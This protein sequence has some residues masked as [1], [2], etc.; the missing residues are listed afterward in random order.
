MASV[1][2]SSHIYIYRLALPALRFPISGICM[3]I[4]QL[5]Q[6][7]AI[8]KHGQ[9]LLATA[10]NDNNDNSSALT[11]YDCIIYVHMNVHIQIY[12]RIHIF[13]CK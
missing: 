11:Q 5:F 6:F 7:T 3:P 1:G 12:D 8:S 10:N 2:F 9:L 13:T 4:V